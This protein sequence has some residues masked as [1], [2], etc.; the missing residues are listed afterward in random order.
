[1]VIENLKYEGFIHKV[2]STEI[3]LKFNER[4][5]H[6]YDSENCQV[7]F[8]SSYTTIQRCHN[9]VNLALNRLGP[10]F[11]FPTKIVQKEPQ[12]HLEEYETE[13]EPTHRRIRH[14]HNKSVSSD[15]SSISSISDTASDNLKSPKMSVA[16]RLFNVKSTESSFEETSPTRSEMNRSFKTNLTNSASKS[17][18]NIAILRTPNESNVHTNDELEPYITQI[19]KRKLNWF[20]KKLNYYQKEAV[21][22]IIL[23]LARPLPY[24]IFGPPGTGKTVTLCETILQLLTTIP[25]SRLLVATPSNS[26]ANLIA[27]RLLDNNILKPGDLVCFLLSQI[28]L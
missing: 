15:S 6:E 7:T 17:K 2:K 3:Y 4:F 28:L 19:K 5:H 18:T 23:G 22:N 16:E 20:N 14:R 10:D 27:E 1:M 25:E 8:K 9:A 11:L 21:R 12:F 13:E 24:V 26:S